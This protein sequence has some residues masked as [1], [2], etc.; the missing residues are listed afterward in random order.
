M[1]KNNYIN[2][3]PTNTPILN[4]GQGIPG[5]DNNMQ[6]NNYKKPSVPYLNPVVV[7][8]F[9]MIEGEPGN[10]V[11]VRS[12]KSDV[13]PHEKDAFV[14]LINEKSSRGIISEDYSVVSALDIAKTIPGM[15]DTTTAATGV[16]DIPGG[17]Q[18][19]RF[20]FFLKTEEIVSPTYIKI[21]LV[22]GYT[23]H[24]GYTNARN[25]TLD[26]NMLMYPN[27]VT[28][29]D[30][31]LTSSSDGK[32]KRWVAG[33]ERMYNVII[34][35]DKQTY[36]LAMDN[37]G[38]RLLRESDILSKIYMDNHFSGV[39]VED[40]SNVPGDIPQIANYTSNVDVSTIASTI[41]HVHLA[42]GLTALS[43]VHSQNDMY[44][45]A[46]NDAS[47]AALNQ[48]NALFKM[49]RH[50]DDLWNYAEFPLGALTRL[51]P[52]LLDVT[53]F[54]MDNDKAFRKN[55]KVS[56]LTHANSASTG[57]T[58]EE[59]KVAMDV[60]SYITAMMGTSGITRIGI[61][62]NWGRGRQLEASINSEIGVASILY[63]SKS[64]VK[65]IGRDKVFVVLEM[66]KRLLMPKLMALGLD[67]V[68]CMIE[69]SLT[70]TNI[71]ISINGRPLTPF[72]LDTFGDSTFAFVRGTEDNLRKLSRNMQDTMNTMFTA[73]GY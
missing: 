42:K 39:H 46:L 27:R 32:R 25:I 18:T 38:E 65:H 36:S 1:H 37:N 2:N 64:A 17:F 16:A 43:G 15:L 49:L 11:Y 26:K 24:L 51:F 60:Y 34:N 20:I 47:P 44:L 21:T 6:T 40:H 45:Q 68:V 56:T 57:E 7:K 22:Q 53:T 69:A 71:H 14:D 52:N 5:Y 29:V 31:T 3:T 48:G 8:E 73:K 70:Y 72:K 12:K 41:N 35:P 50:K 9:M 4:V 58:N 61:D 67:S 54:I 30:F 19:P 55:Y 59:A 10:D 63:N 62:F 13:S 23:S 66:M 33:N 28:E